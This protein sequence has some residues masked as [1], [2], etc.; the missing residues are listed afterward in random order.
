MID[1]IKKNLYPFFALTLYVF[2][3]ISFP[4]SGFLVQTYYDTNSIYFFLIPHILSFLLLPYIFSDKTIHRTCP[5]FCIIL[6]IITFIYAFLPNYKLLFLIGVFSFFPAIKSILIYNKTIHKIFISALALSSG[7]FLTLFLSLTKIPVFVG[8]L[9]ITIAIIVVGL[10]P[11]KFEDKENEVQN[12]DKSQLFLIFTFYLTG[13]MMFDWFLPSYIEKALFPNIELLFYILAVIIGIFFLKR[14]SEI[15]LI[16][17]ILSSSL[18]FFLYKIQTPL[19]FNLGT[20]FNQASFGFVDFFIINLFF[21]FTKWLKKL[22][23]IFATMLLGILCGKIISS[24][25]HDKNF[26]IIETCNLFLII[27]SVILFL[28]HKFKEKKMVSSP[29]TK[30]LDFFDPPKYEPIEFIEPDLLKKLSQQEKKVLEAILKNKRYAEIAE[31]L[32]I[33]VSTVKTYMHRIYEKT[34][35][36]S[37]E[38]LIKKMRKE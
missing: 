9:L 32:K 7:N 28:S 26:M 10:I 20:Y 11:L 16:L 13:G 31:E 36:N 33:S 14:D 24:F 6:G 23:L 29:I 5:Y 2:W 19:F 1:D 25:L 18:S 34:N 38:E 30:T 21:S 3:L 8:F 22:C 12:L 17:G 37:K 15:L 4:M 27:S 35:T